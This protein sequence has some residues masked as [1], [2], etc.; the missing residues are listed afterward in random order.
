MPL[1]PPAPRLPAHTRRV[2]Y[3]GFPREDGLWDIEGELHDSKA[4]DLAMRGRGTLVAG[5]PIHHMLVRLTIDDDMKIVDIAAAME[6]TPFGECSE[7]APPVRGL[8]GVTL[9][10]GW[11]R[12]IDEAMGGTR[13]CT[14]L[15]ELLFGTA[16]A[17]FQTMGSHREQM[18]IERGEPVQPQAE[19]PYYMGQCMSWAFDGP[20]V[21]RIAPEFAGWQPLVRK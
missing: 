15:R 1:P 8:V 7:A 11:R 10:R 6:A 2:T 20:V 19:P 3:R 13:G 12:A 4:Y 5:A 17:A 14:H 18:R 9:G 16:T 21:A